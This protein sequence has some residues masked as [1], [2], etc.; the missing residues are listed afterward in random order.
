MTVTSS[1][2]REVF[3]APD[4]RK[5]RPTATV[6]KR[7]GMGNNLIAVMRTVKRQECSNSLGLDQK[8]NLSM[9]VTGMN[10]Q[11]SKGNKKPGFWHSNLFSMYSLQDSVG[12][13]PKF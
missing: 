5:H 12:N 7:R 1:G 10:F 2:N 8:D 4:Q 11:R 9:L 6:R 3:K 13:F